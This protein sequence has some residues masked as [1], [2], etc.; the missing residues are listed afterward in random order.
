MARVRD[1]QGTPAH[2]ECL[3]SNDKRRH[4]SYCIF[5]DGTGKNRICTNPLCPLYS[6]SCNSARFCDYYEEIQN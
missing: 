3:K 4:P 5:H 1:M 6:E 2:I